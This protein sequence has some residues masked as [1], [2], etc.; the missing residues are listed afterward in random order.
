MEKKLLTIAALALIAGITIGFLI[1]NRLNR[2]EMETL[3]NENARLKAPKDGESD[4]SPTLTAEEIRSRIA[5]ADENPSDLQYQRNL[6]VALYRYAS[7]KKDVPLLAE[8]TRLLKRALP[9]D[10]TGVDINAVL[11][12]AYFDIAYFG[13]NPQGYSEARPFYES[14]LKKKP[15][16]AAIRTD[17]G[18][19]FFLQAPPDYNRALAEF[20]T[21]LRTDPKNERALEFSIQAFLKLNDSLSARKTLDQLKA[22]NSSN[23]SIAGLTNEVYGNTPPAK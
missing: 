10:A 2:I 5:K 3:R 11:G 16:D 21:A 12:N 20:S 4:Q 9:A 6:G 13:E 1:A 14:A 23:P 8:S 19:T 17:Y 18:L 22:V 7:M 15:G